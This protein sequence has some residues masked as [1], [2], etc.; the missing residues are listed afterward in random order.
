[1]AETLGTAPHF[2]FIVTLDLAHM[3]YHRTLLNRLYRKEV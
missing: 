3:C 2:G 1:M